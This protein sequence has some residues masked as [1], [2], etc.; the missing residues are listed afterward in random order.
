MT[1]ERQHTLGHVDCPVC[2]EARHFGMLNLSTDQTFPDAAK[3]WLDLMTFRNRNPL[4]RSRYIAPRTLKDYCQY[5]KSLESFFKELQLGQIHIGHIRQYQEI[6]SETAGSNKINQELGL[7]ERVM[8]MA[9]AWSPELEKF[10]MPLDREIADIPRSMTPR[11]QENFLQVAASREEWRLV[12]FYSLLALHTTAS[13]CEMRGLRVGDLNLFDAILYIRRDHAKNK[14]RVRTIPLTQEAE[15]AAARMMEIAAARGSTGPHNYLFPFRLVRD[16]WDPNK[17]MTNSG[18]KKPFNEIR[19]AAG[20][21]WLRIHDLRHS[22]ITR[23]AEAGTPLAVI[24]SM[25][26]HISGRMVQHYTQISEQAK[27]RALSATYGEVRRPPE[28]DHL[29]QFRL[30]S[31]K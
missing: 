6:R 11:E 20:L 26:G 5:A 24:M 1:T 10:Y 17:P 12:H 15:W 19:K 14:Y 25:A 22:A 31:V 27:R 29:G 2:A 9:G 7:L 3:L 28:H 16:T 4:G 8:K 13:N 30:R 23:L 18:I 21:P